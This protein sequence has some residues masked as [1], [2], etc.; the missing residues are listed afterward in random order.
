MTGDRRYASA[1]EVFER[2]ARVDL[3]LIVSGIRRGSDFNHSVVICVQRR[4]RF[5]RMNG[6][7]AIVIRAVYAEDATLNVVRSQMVADIV[8]II[9]CQRAPVLLRAPCAGGA[10]L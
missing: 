3:E 2:T 1:A 6:G 4:T 8:R 9:R 5:S 7:I 10:F